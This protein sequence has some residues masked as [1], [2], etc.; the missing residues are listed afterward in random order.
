MANKSTREKSAEKD[1][2][3]NGERTRT[4]PDYILSAI[5]SETGERGEVITLAGLAEA[6]GGIKVLN[7][8]LSDRFDDVLCRVTSN[9]SVK[10]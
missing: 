10:L 9:K 8:Y 1:E 4:T 2:G 5:D 3:N 7:K 6:R